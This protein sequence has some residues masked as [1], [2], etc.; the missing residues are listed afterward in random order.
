MWRWEPLALYDPGCSTV[1][2][3][4]P[5]IW[6]AFNH[7]SDT[8]CG[9]GG[10]RVSIPITNSPIL[11]HQLDVQHFSSIWHYLCS[12]QTPQGKGSVPQ[13]CPHFW[14]SEANPKSYY[15]WPT[16]YKFRSFHDPSPPKFSNSL[17]WFT[18]LRGV[19]CCYRFIIKEAGTAKW[20]RYIGRK[21]A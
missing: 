1:L 20:K 5:N 15:F 13:G 18:E 12:V 7:T 19:L 11:L 21:G 4:N 17:E 16:G 2:N 10:G 9:G 14:P 6:A 3:P 8:K